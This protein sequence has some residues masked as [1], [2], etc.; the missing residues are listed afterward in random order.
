VTRER[1]GRSATYSLYDH[2][3]SSLLDEAVFHAEHLRMGVP[4]RAIE[5]T[6]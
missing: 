5:P 3:V 4:D 1:S 2:H 6:S